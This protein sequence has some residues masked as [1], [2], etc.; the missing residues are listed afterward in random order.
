M[1]KI[2]FILFHLILIVVRWGVDFVDEP[3]LWIV[4]LLTGE[5]EVVRWGVDEK[6]FF[7]VEWIGDVIF[8]VEN[9]L[10]SL[11]VDCVVNWLCDDVRCFVVCLV[12]DSHP[13]GYPLIDIFTWQGGF[14]SVVEIIIISIFDISLSN[15][16]IFLDNIL[17]FKFDPLI[18]SITVF[19]S[20]YIFKT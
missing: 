19:E 18:F 12:E 6:R 7:V 11:K 8:F 20:S 9:G 4:E 13:D 10:D 3:E 17:S 5:I 2:I 16:I 1:L 14:L 15:E